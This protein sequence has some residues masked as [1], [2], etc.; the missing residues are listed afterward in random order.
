MIQDKVLERGNGFNVKYYKVHRMNDPTIFKCTLK[1]A[2]K[3]YQQE[4]DDYE[5]G[6][7]IVLFPRN[8]YTICID[9]K[10]KFFFD[11]KHPSKSC[12][13]SESCSRCHKKGCEYCLKLLCR[14][15]NTYC[16][17]NCKN[18]ASSLCKCCN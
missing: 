8:Y 15:C 1:K 16:C 14:D 4:P 6:M 7:G 17:I 9:R 11:D 13:D 10:D 12:D 2:K 5:D 18:N 3:E